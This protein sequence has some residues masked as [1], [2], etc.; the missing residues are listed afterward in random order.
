MA[1]PAK[2]TVDYFP[3]YVAA[4]RTLY[5]LESTFGNDGY[6]FWFKLL[7][8]LGDTEGH[9][10]DCNT[11]GAFEYLCAK[12]RVGEETAN[13]ILDL[14][15]KLKAIDAELWDYRIIWVQHLVDNIADAYR[16]RKCAVP[17]RP[18][19]PGQKLDSEGVSDAG[20]PTN[21]HS[22]D[23]S[24]VGNPQT[25]LNQTKPKE[26][27][28]PL[29]PI[30]SDNPA[31][32]PASPGEG[33]VGERPSPLS[34]LLQGLLQ[35][36]P[37]Y[38]PAE[39]DSL[40]DYWTLIVESKPRGFSPPSVLRMM[41]RWEKHPIDVVIEAV[42]LHLRKYQDKDEGY[43]DGIVARLARERASGVIQP[44]S[45]RRQRRRNKSSYGDAPS[46]P[47]PWDDIRLYK[48]HLPGGKDHAGNQGEGGTSNAGTA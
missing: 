47:S 44:I 35:G 42:E 32:Q 46:G 18:S 2:A 16:K 3:H 29:P 28:P 41:Q 15:A 22:A 30:G 11:T 13:Q 17:R 10:Y 14:L 26:I 34:T 31:E 36:F 5:I 19:I 39:R 9:A 24:D 38:G 7:E 4:G 6:A 12:A 25:K 45:D 8:V 20:N 1:R 37:R 48:T 27:T 33:C 43:T 21:L 40:L 23:V